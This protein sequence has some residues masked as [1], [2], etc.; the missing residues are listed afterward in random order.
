MDGKKTSFVNAQRKT[1]NKQTI[2]DEDLMTDSV[3][4]QFFGGLVVYS[5]IKHSMT[6]PVL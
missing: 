4:L 2:E 5:Q 3:F 1:K 6:D